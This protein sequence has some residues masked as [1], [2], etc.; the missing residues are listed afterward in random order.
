MGTNI[1]DRW[2]IWLADF[3]IQRRWFVILASI[4]LVMAT[5]TGARHLEFANNYRA[6]FGA[7]NPELLNFEAFQSTYTKNDNIL[8]VVQ[9]KE[10]KLFSPAQASAIERIT[11]AAWKT[12]F[13]IRVDS[14]TNFQHSW[15]NG[16]DL[17]VEDLVRDGKTMPQAELDRRTAIALAEPLLRGNLISRDSD[18]TGIN[19]VLQYPEKSLTEVPEAVAYVR[20]IRAD[21]EKDFPD[22]KIALTGVSML[23]NT[24]AESGQ[25]DV[26]T[27]IPIMYGVLLTFMV[28]MLRS[29]SGT[30]GTLLVIGFSTAGAMGFAGYMG[31]K[32]TP[33]SVTAPTIVLTLAIADSIHLLVTQFGFMR[34]GVDKISALKESIRI[35]A[36]AVTITSITTIV[37]FL[38]LN[39]SDSPPFHDLGN[40][41]AAGIVAA[42]MLSLTFLPAVISLLPIR[43]REQRHHVGWSERVLG[44]VADFV[45]GRYRSILAVFG[46]I[47]IGLTAMVPTINL[48]DQWVKYFDHRVPFRDDAEFA[49]ENLAGLYPVEFSVKAGE[50]GGISNPEYLKH[51]EEFTAWLRTRP[52]VRHVYSYTDIIKRLNKNMHGDDEAWYK[53]PEERKL[54]AQFLL[55]YEMSL[56]FGLDLN[57]R[58][59]IDKSAT[60]VTAT[61]DEISTADLRAFLDTSEAWLQKNTPPAMHASPTSASVMFAYISERNI[62]SMLRGNVVAVFLIAVIMAMALRS[63]GMGVLSILPNAL[64]ILMT[65]G[66]WA[67]LVGQVGMASATVTATALGIVVDDSVHLLTKYLRG[68]REKGL[69]TEDSIRY[70]FRTVGPAILTTTVILTTGFAVLAASTFKIN[71]EMGLLTALAIALAVV[72]DFLVLPALL[73]IGNN[74][75]ESEDAVLVSA[76]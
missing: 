45:I 19:I 17:T 53:I 18:T 20:S 22:L 76:Q 32:L 41:T 71:S 66:L 63:V 74:K 33:I 1:S 59:N 14:V 10:G 73:L 44:R 5:A 48:D 34:E 2:A 51:L 69:S 30:I 57:D 3:V 67:L 12:P 24:F 75:K 55:L 39:F 25:M 16:D 49:I 4:V 43:V 40:I 29:F 36:L 11:K 6:F 31:I 13:S 21:I 62:E 37:G 60:R 42:W 26:M 58:V 68:R 72:F 28:I 47:T 15:A 64:P 8:F 52:E 56:P 35:N 27:L 70:A 23:N 50:P 9:P 65:F 61:L 46:V 54:G 7:D 38:S